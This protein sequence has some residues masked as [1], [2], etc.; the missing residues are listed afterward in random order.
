MQAMKFMTGREVD[1]DSDKGERWKTTVTKTGP[2]D[3]SALFGP[4]VR[5]FFVF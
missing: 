3:V 4:L 1:G 2:N 5:V